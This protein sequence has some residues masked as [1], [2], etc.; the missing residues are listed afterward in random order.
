MPSSWSDYGS[1]NRNKRD[2]GQ[3]AEAQ[4]KLDQQAEF[5]KNISD[6]DKLQAGK[7]N[8]L[9]QS[10]RQFS[11]AQVGRGLGNILKQQNLQ[12]QRRGIEFSPLGGRG[13]MEQ[14]A[15]LQ[16]QGLQAQQSYA[17][18]LDTLMYQ[19]RDKFIAGEFKFIH[20]MDYAFQQKQF[21]VDLANLQASLQRDQES[22]SNMFALAGSIG[23]F[24]VG[25]P[26]GSA[27]GGWLGTKTG[28][29][30]MQN[31]WVSGLA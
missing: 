31:P 7:R 13:M 20:E 23:G 27:I 30:P 26:I 2:T 16:G 17:S 19:N 1:Q 10:F 9:L 14:Q 6:Y 5:N 28:S 3:I 24:L 11:E 18:A 4:R 15:A 29:P 21:A 25:G 22:R 8:D 12:N